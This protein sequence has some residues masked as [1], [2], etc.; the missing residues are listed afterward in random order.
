MRTIQLVDREWHEKFAEA[1]EGGLSDLRIICPFIKAGTIGWLLGYTQTKVQVIT[2]FNLAD[3]AAGVSD[4]SAMRKLLDAKARVRGVKNLHAKLYIFG[5]SRAFVTSCNLTGAALYRNHEFGMVIDDEKIVAKCLTYFD[6][7]WQHAGEDLLSEQVRSWDSHITNHWLGG[8]LSK[9]T[10]VLGDFGVDVGMEPE[11]G[12][13]GLS[14]IPQAFVKIG[15][16]SSD[17]A[18]LS[19]TTISDVKDG[20]NHWAVC[21]PTNKRPIRV[22][23]GAIVFMG[24]LTSNP[25]DIRVYGR[26]VGMAYEPG[27]DDASLADKECRPWKQ[28]WS[29]YIRVHD[30]EFVAGTMENGV[31]VNELMDS[32]K[33]DSFASTQRNAERGHGNTNPRRAYSQQP[34]V[35]LSA[36]GFRWLNERLEATFRA[37][38]TISQE[39]LA[40]LDW[41]DLASITETSN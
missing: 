11:V 4:T 39:R 1:L 8:G 3:F 34:A 5:Q 27:R 20:G 6:K 7:L 19:H 16:T 12:P 37:H 18:E 9:D 33:A 41:P 15:G 14:D 30:P 31:S 26:A 17:R 36:E 38:G 13:I 25:N 40:A 10:S 32:L 22:K 35:E 21:Y 29:R 28:Q 23:D 2:R 24:R